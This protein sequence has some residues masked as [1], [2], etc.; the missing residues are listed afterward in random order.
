MAQASRFAPPVALC[1]MRATAILVRR[2]RLRSTS[3]G[4]RGASPGSWSEPIRWSS[5]RASTRATRHCKIPARRMGNLSPPKA[6]SP[7]AA[8]A[9]S[10][11]APHVMPRQAPPTRPMRSAG[12]RRWRSEIAMTE[13]APTARPT[14]TKPT[15]ARAQP[16]GRRHEQ[17]ADARDRRR[18]DQGRSASEP[19]HEPRRYDA[20]QEVSGGADGQEDAVGR[21]P[22]VPHGRGQQHQDSALHALERSQRAHHREE[23]PEPAIGEQVAAALPDRGRR[24]GGRPTVLGASARGNG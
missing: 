22:D 19:R 4:W 23:H 15:P 12:V 9:P 24:R 6:A 2:G 3:T 21:R 1:F 11:A 10:G 7:P 16:V 18:R 13:P 14:I 17:I 5:G 8:R 20:A